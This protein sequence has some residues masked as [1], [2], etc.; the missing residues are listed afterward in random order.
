M[1]S[2]RCATGWSAWSRTQSL[3]SGWGG[4]RARS[5]RI[6]S[7]WTRMPIESRTSWWVCRTASPDNHGSS[8]QH[9]AQVKGFRACFG[10]VALDAANAHQAVERVRS[11][12]GSRRLRSKVLQ[13]QFHLAIGHSARQRNEQIRSTE[14][15]FVLGN[16]VLE[17]QVIPEGVP[18]Q[19]GDQPVVLVNV[20]P[21]VGEY[22]VRLHGSLDLL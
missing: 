13:D 3:R 12:P 7:T 1:T 11:K 10:R 8:E 2:M 14:I 4:A 15:A 16:F 21:V 22:D 5:A 17:H 19:L 6:G 9:L 18:R 20:V